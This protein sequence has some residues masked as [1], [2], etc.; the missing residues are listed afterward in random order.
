MNVFDYG[1]KSNLNYIDILVLVLLTGI[2]RIAQRQFVFDVLFNFI[3]DK[4][5]F[6]S[7][8][9]PFMIR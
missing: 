4:A 9:E 5:Q 8:L 2:L 1:E 6:S 3:S 7:T